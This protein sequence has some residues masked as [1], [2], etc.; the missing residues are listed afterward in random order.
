M[1][2]RKRRR[3][4]QGQRRRLRRRQQQQK[5]YNN[6]NNNNIN[7]NNNN[8]KHLPCSSVKRWFFR[9]EAK[10]TQGLLLGLATIRR[11][12]DVVVDEANQQ[13]HLL[14]VMDKLESHYEFDTT[15]FGVGPK[16]RC[17][18]SVSCAI[19]KCI[20]RMRYTILVW[21]QFRY[22]NIVKEEKKAS[23]L[24]QFCIRDDFIKCLSVGIYHK[25][26]NLFF[27]ENTSHHS[28]H[29]LKLWINI[30]KKI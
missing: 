20:S 27:H 1:R 11:Q 9:G 19:H 3:R 30:S 10:F 22:N 7:N 17:S 2:R 18:V 15:I 28:S 29:L 13:A 8:N 25:I 26:G 21:T 24:L 12:G 4:W 5:K 16:G 14:L 6:N 23:C